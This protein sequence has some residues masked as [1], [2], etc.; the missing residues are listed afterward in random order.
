VPVTL[1]DVTEDPGRLG[2]Y[3]DKGITRAVRIAG[4]QI[5]VDWSRPHPTD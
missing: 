3:R 1:S 4:V 2:R 5:F